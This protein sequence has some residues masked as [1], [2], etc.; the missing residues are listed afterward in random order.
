MKLITKNSDRLVG[1]IL[2]FIC[3]GIV[4]LINCKKF[5]QEINDYSD[6][7]LG[8]LFFIAGIVQLCTWRTGT[9]NLSENKIGN[10]SEFQSNSATNDTT[11]KKD[12]AQE[13][14]N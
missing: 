11:G 4:L 2:F 3:S 6:I 13:S 9:K 8:I 7:M 14:D 10:E 5:F 1:A 12:G